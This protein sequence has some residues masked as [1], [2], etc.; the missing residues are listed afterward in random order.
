MRSLAVFALCLFSFAGTL[1]AEPEGRTLLRVSD[2]AAS[3]AAGDY[4]RDGLPDLLVLEPLEGATRL[5]LLRDVEQRRGRPEARELRLDRRY[6]RM[7]VGDFDADGHPDAL[8]ARSRGTR[9][10]PVHL[11]LDDGVLRLAAGEPRSLQLG[12]DFFVAGDVNRV[13]GLTDIVVGTSGREGAELLVFEGPQ[14]ALAAQPEVVRLPSAAQGLRLLKPQGRGATSIGVRLAGGEQVLLGRDRMLSLGADRREAVAAPRLVEAGPERIVWAMDRSEAATAV[15]AGSRVKTSSRGS[16]YLGFDGRIHFA[17]TLLATLTVNDAG[18][19]GDASPGDG[20]CDAGGGACTLRAAIEEANALA[21]ADTI[22]FALGGGTPTIAPVTALP[23]ITESAT[24]E[25]ATGG[26][27]RIEI[28][29]TSVPGS[30]LVANSDF[31]TLRGLVINGFGTDGVQLNGSDNVVEDCYLG[32]DASGGGSVSGNGRYGVRVAGSRNRIGGATVSQRNVISNNLDGVR[33]VEGFDNL[34]QGNFIGLDGSGTA[35]LPQRTGVLLDGFGVPATGANLVGGSVVVP[36]EPPGNLIAGHTVREIQIGISDDNLVQGNLIGTDASGAQRVGEGTVRLSSPTDCSDNLVGGS[37]ASLR[38]V[39][40]GVRISG[41]FCVRT[42]IQG[43]FVGLAADGVSV[44]GGL[45]V[46]VEGLDFVNDHTVGGDAPAPGSPPGNVIAGC[47]QHGINS[48]IATLT[49]DG[50]LIGLAADGVTVP[51]NPGYG[52]RW[53]AKAGS[54]FGGLD[55]GGNNPGE[56]NVIAGN[57]S[58][59]ITASEGGGTFI[60]G[61]WIGVDAA[62][63]PAPNG[64]AGVVVSDNEFVVGEAPSGGNVIAG[65]DGAGVIAAGNTLGRLESNLIG[66]LPDGV[67]PSGNT[68]AGVDSGFGTVT[69]GGSRLPSGTCEGTCNVI[70]HNGGDGVVHEGN[71]TVVGNEIRDNGGL[72]VDILPDGPDANVPGRPLNRP[73]IVNV[74]PGGSD[75]QVDGVLNAGADR[76][77]EIHVYGLNVADPSGFGEMDVFLGETTCNTDGAGDCSWSV[78]VTSASA[79]TASATEVSVASPRTSELALNSGSVGPDAD[80]DGVADGSDNCPADFNPGQADGDGDGLGDACDGC[81]AASD[82][83]QEDGDGDGV[84]DACD[85]CP[86]D[87]NADQADLDG[88]QVGDVCDCAPTVPGG[89][90]AEVA[91]LEG[92]KLTPTLA[93]FV[94]E[95][96]ALADSYSVTRGL[97]SGLGG[98]DYGICFGQDLTLSQIQDP[99]IPPAGEAFVYLVQAEAVCGLGTLGNDSGGGERVNQNPAACAP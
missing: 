80:S 42:L 86:L 31:V 78:T 2:P 73:E 84:G 30:G 41:N 88:D 79:Y 8:L 72:A 46:D 43:N 38:N 89:L 64:G 76:D 48:D 97:L 61:N 40:G 70:A 36:G 24:I 45:C 50:N 69:V 91:S 19:A 68:G 87:A 82:P 52:I 74:T 55:V 77:Y 17:E 85:N 33:V 54:S 4:D 21:G 66:V 62:G 20:A 15:P 93:L 47:D 59:A 83:G 75:D 58:G 10:Q 94:W 81:P 13:D 6:E 26:A 63:G 12:F 90:P 1:V 56:R 9:L 57:A 23:P 16:A 96:D 39:L 98:A 18:D 11:G 51:G 71:T 29:G 27:T 7:L 49:I 22:Q 35:A 92:A 60:R 32:P 53:A 14:G 34:I 28:Q 67:T 25:G 95:S 65:N 99:T 3:L 44:L 5:I 37:S